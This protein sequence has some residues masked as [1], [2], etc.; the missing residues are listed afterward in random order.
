MKHIV[1]AHALIWYLES[2]PLLGP[3][4]KTVMDDPN[5][6]LLLP[7]IALAEV[8]WVV[9]RGKT[10]I[11]SVADLLRDV[12]ADSRIQI[13]PLDRETFDVSLTLTSIGEMHDRQIVALAVLLQNQG[14]VVALL[15]KD[16]NIVASGLVPIVW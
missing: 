15:T 4:A 9:G 6:E 12:D 14:E 3:Q 8:C 16:S 7:I 11:P 1:D 13:V 2:N 5:A 10:R